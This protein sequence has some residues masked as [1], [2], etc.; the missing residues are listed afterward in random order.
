MV[1]AVEGGLVDEARFEMIWFLNA[2]RMAARQG[3][4]IDIVVLGW[5]NSGL[6]DRSAAESSS[7]RLI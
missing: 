2:C 4:H 7:L 3:A 1:C 5:R 6:F